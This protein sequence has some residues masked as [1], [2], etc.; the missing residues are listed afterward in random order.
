MS[1]KE[2]ISFLFIQVEDLLGFRQSLVKA[3]LSFGPRPMDYK[4]KVYSPV[5]GGLAH[6]IWLSQPAPAEQPRTA[7]VQRGGSSAQRESFISNNGMAPH[8]SWAARSP[9]CLERLEGPSPFLEEAGLR[10]R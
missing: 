2:Q 9:G 5:E 1:T 8:G 3:L 7:P 10:N 6:L 4:P